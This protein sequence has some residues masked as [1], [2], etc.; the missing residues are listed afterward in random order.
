MNRSIVALILS[1][2]ACGALAAANA[3][4]QHV[5]KASTAASQNASAIQKQQ[6]RRVSAA[7]H[8]AT[9]RII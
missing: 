4:S 8:S 9:M 5:R 2:H 7:S 1:V 6:Q 3:S